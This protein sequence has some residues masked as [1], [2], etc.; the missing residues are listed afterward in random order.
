MSSSSRLTSQ[1]SN[2]LHPFPDGLGSLGGLTFGYRQYH[3]DYSLSPCVIGE[4]KRHNQP[5]ILESGQRQ[6]RRIT[7]P[8]PRQP[9]LEPELRYITLL[10]K[11]TLCPLCQT[12]HRQRNSPSSASLSSLHSRSQKA[13]TLISHSPPPPTLIPNLLVDHSRSSRLSRWTAAMEATRNMS[14]MI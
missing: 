2:A 7:L 14:T 5:P 1:P 12:H 13:L 10:G 11:Q 9:F 4:L 3:L 6:L 8:Q